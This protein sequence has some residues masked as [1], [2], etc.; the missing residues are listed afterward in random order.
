MTEHTAQTFTPYPGFILV[1]LIEQKSSSSYQEAYDS[2]KDPIATGEVVSL[3]EPGLHES[4]VELVP[5]VK[6]GDMIYFKPY[7]VDKIFLD[8]VEH[9]IVSFNNIRGTLK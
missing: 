6:V 7:G 9:R 3:G 4:G 8:S 2:D 5:H 1:K